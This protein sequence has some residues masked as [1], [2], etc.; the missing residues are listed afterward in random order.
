[1]IIWNFWPFFKPPDP[2]PEDPWIRIQSGSGSGSRSK[3]LGV[4]QLIY[5]EMP[6]GLLFKK[7]KAKSDDVKIPQ[8]WK[9]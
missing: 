2:D 6:K 1:M 3:T 8:K 4:M 7:S 9:H 5:T